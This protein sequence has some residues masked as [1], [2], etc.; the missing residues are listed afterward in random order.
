MPLK[1]ILAA[2]LQSSVFQGNVLIG[3][4]NF[5]KYYPSVSGSSV[6]AGRWKTGVD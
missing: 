3:M 6:Y 4:E 1:I 5:S 2:G